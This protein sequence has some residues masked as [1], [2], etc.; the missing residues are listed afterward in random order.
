MNFRRVALRLV[1]AFARVFGNKLRDSNGKVLCKAFVFMWRGHIRII[2][3]PNNVHLKPVAVPQARLTYWHQIIGWEHA[4]PPDFPRLKDAAATKENLSP[5]ICHVVICH[6]SPAETKAVADRWQHHDP[7]AYILIAYGGSEENFHRLPE[8]I[9]AIF[10]TDPALR[11]RDH[12]RERQQYQDVFRRASQWIANHTE[13]VTHVGVVEFDVAPAVM[14]ISNQLHSA[15]TSQNADM[16]GYGMADLTG[17][18]HPHYRHQ[19]HDVTFSNF[20]K[21]ISKR[22]NPTRLLTMLGCCSFW[23][24]EAFEKVASLDSTPPVYLE[25]GMPTLAHHLGFRVRPMPADQEK[26]VTFQG[27]YSFRIDEF[28]NQGAWLVHPCKLAVPLF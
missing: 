10:I 5:K 15:L 18:I 6:I 21:S 20:L 11:T 19:L 1:I 27:D 12:V 25:I 2:G 14:N 24:R 28:R 17:T 16:V 8:E 4:L 3:Q 7:D 13:N 22:E 9:N 26:F 23:S